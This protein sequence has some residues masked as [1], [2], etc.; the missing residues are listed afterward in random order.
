MDLS[1]EFCDF[2]EFIFEKMTAQ[3]ETLGFK[4]CITGLAIGQEL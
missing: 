2:S 3:W 4:T 1:L